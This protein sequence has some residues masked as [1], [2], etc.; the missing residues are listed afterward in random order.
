MKEADNKVC[1]ICESLLE[2]NGACSDVGNNNCQYLKGFDSPPCNNECY[3]N[4][5]KNVQCNSE[6]DGHVCSRLPK[7][8]G[9]HV[10]CGA[11]HAVFIWKDKNGTNNM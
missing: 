7:H 2:D 11:E 10:A 9:R 3:E 1:P 6:K 4:I 5:N 8:S